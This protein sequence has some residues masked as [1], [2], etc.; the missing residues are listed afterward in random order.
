MLYRWMIAAALIISLVAPHVSAQ[1]SDSADDE[2]SRLIEMRTKQADDPGGD[3]PSVPGATYYF[4]LKNGD[5]SRDCRSREKPC[6]TTDRA[7]KVVKEPGTFALFERGNHWVDQSWL[8]RLASGTAAAPITIG[9]YGTGPRPI[10]TKGDQTPSNYTRI[11]NKAYINF[12]RLDIRK[13]Q[14]LHIIERSHHLKFTHTRIR[15]SGNACVQMAGS[16]N[17]TEPYHIYFTNVRIEKCGLFGNN[18]EGFYISESI[19]RYGYGGR[20]IYITDSVI[21][22]TEDEPV[23][24]KSG[25]RRVVIT[26]TVIYNYAP[27]RETEKRDP[28]LFNFRLSDDPNAGHVLHSNIVVGNEGQGSSKDAAFFL[29]PG[30]SA[31]N[32]LIIGNKMACVRG[33]KGGK[34]YLNT[35]VRNAKGFVYPEPVKGSQKLD[36]DDMR[37]NIGT[38]AGNNVDTDDKM[39]VDIDKQ[40]LRLSKPNADLNGGCGLNG[41]MTDILGRPRQGKWS[42]GAFEYKD[43]TPPSPPPKSACETQFGTVDDFKLCSETETTCSFYARLGGKSCGEVCGAMGGTCLDAFDNIGAGCKVNSKLD[44]TC[45]SKRNT[46]ICIC[47]KMP[48]PPPP[49]VKPEPVDVKWCECGCSADKDGGEEAPETL[50]DLHHVGLCKYGCAA[51]VDGSVKVPMEQGQVIGPVMHE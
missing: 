35:C 47:S 51:C 14:A 9:A 4:S 2:G 42:F 7:V 38:G 18:G 50:G 1:P 15:E 43:A 30:V 13:M 23:N 32:N 25:T 27:V 40:D 17:G 44:D 10:F 37:C 26:G 24:V 45:D 28:G 33:D 12:D 49:P 8:E 19:K 20:D 41:E 48:P 36:I 39:F 31:F 29:R 34:F 3:T 5:D 22:E 11:S 16:R 21:T 6:K 46:E